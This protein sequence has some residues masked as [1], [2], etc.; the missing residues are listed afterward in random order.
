ML[1][2]ETG[3]QFSK[4]ASGICIKIYISYFSCINK[5]HFLEKAVFGLYTSFAIG[6]MFLS[7][8]VL[9]ANTNLFWIIQ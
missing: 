1:F 9:I 6:I 4:T 7:S 5:C 3:Q 8:V 2:L